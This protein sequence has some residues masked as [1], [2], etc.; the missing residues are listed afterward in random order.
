MVKK[1]HRN[2]LSANNLNDQKMEVEDRDPLYFQKINAILDPKMQTH[3]VEIG[4][5]EIIQDS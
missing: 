3:W 2:Y 1:Y 5:E 4:L